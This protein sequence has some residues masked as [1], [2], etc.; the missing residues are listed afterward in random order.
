MNRDF[1]FAPLTSDERALLEATMK[2][3]APDGPLRASISALH[4]FLTSVASGP[5][6]LPSDWIPVVFGDVDENTF[7]SVEDAQRAVDLVLRFYNE[8]N[9]SLVDNDG[10]FSILSDVLGER[11]EELGIEDLAIGDNWCRGYM[12]GVLVPEDAWDPVFVDER[13]KAAFLTIAAHAKDDREFLD[14]LKDPETYTEAL[15]AV[16][17]CV[18]LLHEWWQERL[19]SEVPDEV[20]PS[21]TVR[22]QSAKIGPNAPCPCGSGK[23]YKKCCSPVRVV[24]GG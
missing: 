19:A 11:G 23:K 1:A 18:M 9:D 13:A 22:R 10:T 12:V 8:V 15:G 16:P 20:M 5:I 7:E 3:A 24:P 21:G 2:Q 17:H 4:G 6:L 14:P